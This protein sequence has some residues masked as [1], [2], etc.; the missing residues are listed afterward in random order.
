[1]PIVTGRVSNLNKK[2]YVPAGL[3][4]VVLI[5]VLAYFLYADFGLFLE[6][7]APP[8]IEPEPTL[9]TVGEESSVKLKYYPSPEVKIYDLS[10]D[11]EGDLLLFGSNTKKA[12]LI[13]EDGNIVWEQ[14]MENDPLQTCIT[15]CGSYIAIGTSGGELFFMKNSG[16]VLWE[17]EMENPVKHIAVEPAG[18]WLIC[19][20]GNEEAGKLDFITQDRCKEW[21]RE[22]GEIKALEISAREKMIIYAEEDKDSYKTVALDLAGEEIWSIEEAELKALSNDGDLLAVQTEEGELIVYDK[23]KKEKWNNNLAAKPSQAF[24]NSRNNN[25]LV[26]DEQGVH[27]NLYYFN[28][29]GELLWEKCIADDAVIA[30]SA[31]GQNILFSSKE[32]HDNTF[33]KIIVLDE[34][35]EIVN[36]LEVTVQIEKIISPE[37]SGTL[38][39]A[40]SDGTVFRVDLH[41]NN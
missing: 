12:T 7:E 27:H 17:K 40:G 38:F 20:S 29:H 30:F 33:S 31:D 16:E 13:D 5:L 36:E 3:L 21:T 22:T 15:P 37:D 14:V 32:H 18:E 4:F 26:Y 19:G 8:P 35:G 9:Q 24:F 39:L 1:M 28:P 41:L 11:H 10:I 25:L 34:R 23:N 6:S 2:K